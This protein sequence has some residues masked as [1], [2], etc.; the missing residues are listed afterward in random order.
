M[1]LICHGSRNEGESLL[2]AVCYLKN[3]VCLSWQEK[4][5][6]AEEQ[7]A[8]QLLNI[9]R[10]AQAEETKVSEIAFINE[11]Q[12]GLLLASLRQMTKRRSFVDVTAAHGILHT[13]SL[14][15]YLHLLLPQHKATVT[16]V[17][18]P[19]SSCEVCFIAC[20][21]EKRSPLSEPLLP[22]QCRS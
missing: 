16:N 12:A 20:L 6:R 19:K 17:R 15:H 8:M 10:K 14:H 11:L 21:T 5:A 22:V 18:T 13:C 9:K 7:R 1:Q 4:L 2:R 3:C